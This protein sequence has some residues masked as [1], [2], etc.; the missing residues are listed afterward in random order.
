MA[1]SST[2]RVSLFVVRENHGMR[3]SKKASGRVQKPILP[4]L[5]GWLLGGLGLLG[6]VVGGYLY[7][8]GVFRAMPE[9]AIANSP[10]LSDPRFILGIEGLTNA[11]STTGRMVGFWQSADE[12]YAARNAAIR[13]ATALI[14]YETYFMTP[15]RRADEFAEVL[16]ERTAA[17]TKVQ[18]LLDHHGTAKMPED[19]WQRLT[20]AGIEVRFLR[21]PDWRSP[22]EYNSRSHRKL[23][24]IDGRRVLIGGAGV[25]DYWDGTAFDHDTAPWAD[26]EV[27]YEGEVVNLL[28]GKFLQNWAYTGGDLDLTQEISP[29]QTEGATPP[30]T[31]SNASGLASRRFA[32]WCS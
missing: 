6:L 7:L 17:G 9:Y 30:Y 11:E 26:F 14:Q 13:Q 5:S 3:S 25:S 23:L 32:C 31:T 19:Y 16:I 1:S 15:G 10:S 28:Q 2:L 4:I 22:L 12:I 21:P 20:G 18:L 29:V 24:I 27:A 8:R